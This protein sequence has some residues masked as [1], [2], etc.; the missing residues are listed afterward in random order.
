M[1]QMSFLPS[2]ALRLWKREA[3]AS[4]PS[5]KEKF[6]AFT[7]IPNVIKVQ[8]MFVYQLGKLLYTTSDK[9]F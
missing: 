8:G 3:S 6:C 2:V 5:E 4:H 9:I 1:Q 7:Y